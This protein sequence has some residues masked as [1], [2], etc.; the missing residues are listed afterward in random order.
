M[1]LPTAGAQ[2]TLAAPAISVHMASS[3]PP[4]RQLPIL[5]GTETLP[6]LFQ[7]WVEGF[8]PGPIPRETKATCLDCAMCGSNGGA[9]PG[10]TPFRP[11]VKC[12]SYLPALPNFL[13][14]RVLNDDDPAGAAG[15][16]SVEA[17]VR[18]RIAVTPLGAGTAPVFA[19][20][21]QQGDA[22]SSKL[23]GRSRALI[24]PHFVDENG[25]LCGIWKYR[26]AVCTTFFCKHER[27][28]VGQQF[29]MD[30]REVLRAAEEELAIWSAMERGL[31]EA[32][33]RRLITMT[34]SRAAT[35]LSTELIDGLEE[36][37]AKQV[38]GQWLGREEEFY[39]ACATD[40][41]ALTWDDVCRIGGSALRARLAVVQ[42]SYRQLRSAEI[43]ARLS[44]KRLSQRHI[45]DDR[46]QVETY[47]PYDP[48]ILSNRVVGLLRYFDGGPTADALDR[49]EQV[50][51]VR[52]T[53]DLVR[54]LADHG[55]LREVGNGNDVGAAGA[56]DATRTLPALGAT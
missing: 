38:W 50:E 42:D 18:S 9:T 15:R 32:T 20:L 45:D 55:I 16:A 12:C 7:R 33:L 44:G 36:V 6:T 43:P 41:E 2:G 46:V 54:M 8:L 31:D 35:P 19:L 14:G 40:V 1:G 52:L 23:F 26:N 51:S 56:G 29:W 5:G 47:S 34:V 39:R 28:A 21:Y 17:R 37:Y 27:G 25:G 53:E 4:T 30:L 49:I 10:Y 48:A 3:S 13:I 24:C 22:S 11:D